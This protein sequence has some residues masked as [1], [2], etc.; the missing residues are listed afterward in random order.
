MQ[1]KTPDIGVDKAVVAEILVKVGDSI[2]ENDSLVLLESDKASV[3]VPSTSAGVVKSILIKE[4]DSVTEGTVL[5][6]LE[7]EG[8]APVAQAEEAPKAAPAAEQ[9]AAPAAAQQPSTA[10]QPATATTSQVVE[11]QVPDI[12]VEKALVGEIL[13][14]V[15]EQIDVEQSIVVV[16][17]DKATVEVPSSVAGT[18][19]SIQ[20]KEG[21]TVKEG[22]V[23]IK[24]KTTSAS[25]APAEA[26][27]STTAAPAAAPAPTQQETVASTAT[28]SG[29]V[30]INVPDL[31]VDK[32][33]VAEILVQVGD[34]VDV[35]QS[36]VVVESD[37]A[38]VEVPSTVAGVVKAIHLQAG[39]QVSQGVLLATI[40]A[41]GQA[42]A[43][44]P[45]A[46]AESAPAP[47]AAAPKAAAPAA[48]QSAPVASTSGA[49]KLTK[50][51]EAENAKVY[52][53]PAVRKL[54]RELG[55]VLSQVK[56]SGEHGRVVKEDIF[57]YVKSRLTAPQAA[58]VA[59]AAPAVSGL[60]KLPDFTAFGGVEEKVLTRL[61]QVSIPQLSLNNFIPQVTQFDL[62]DITELEDWRN[63][64]KGNFKKEGIS[65]TIMA[66]IIKAVAYLLKEEREFAGHL[67]DDGKSVLLRNEIHMGI[68]VAT[69]DGLTVPVLRN[70]DQKSIKQIAVELGMLGQKARDKKLTPKDLQGANFTISSLGAIGG[71]AFTPLVNWPQVAILGISPATMQPVW[72]G[73]DFDPR[74]M[75][76]LSLSYDHRVI[77][78]ADAA[79]FTNKLTKLLKDI[80]TLLI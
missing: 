58:P 71:T 48:T 73:K 51:Q 68:A 52:A 36:L 56:T 25:S 50:E 55:I 21:D 24:V 78:G 18:V 5:L 40:E 11:V 1:I 57:A 22:V 10:A 31:G 45:A 38:T 80:R 72:N 63:E 65:L 19:E 70:P 47:Q 16:E 39:Q 30:D 13:V 37:K 29:P 75:L 27:A 15:G 44:A 46:K 61:Q 12:G 77:N 49:D 41:E 26:P 20:V 14:K 35:D 42:P 34:K 64:L 79:R 7:A 17:S 23:L 9:T 60:P 66:F 28:Q 67:S 4:G 8:A 3:E 54:A 53:G 6:E 74:L 32:A 62:A 69:P 76:P 43:A 2:A 33:V 59:A